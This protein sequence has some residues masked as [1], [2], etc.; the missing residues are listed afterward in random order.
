MQYLL[1]FKTN[2]QV[3]M[4]IWYTLMWGWNKSNY[5]I[6]WNNCVILTKNLPINQFPYC[7]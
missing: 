7:I 2:N 3:P 6:G 1:V 5:S 4:S